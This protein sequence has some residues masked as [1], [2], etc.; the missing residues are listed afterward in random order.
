VSDS[1][2][3]ARRN[4]LRNFYR[5]SLAFE[6]QRYVVPPRMLAIMVQS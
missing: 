1:Q 4:A 2:R 3:A 5:R 6:R